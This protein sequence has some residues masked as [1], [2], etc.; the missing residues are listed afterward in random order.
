MYNYI[1]VV[2]FFCRGRS[3]TWT[4]EDLK[5]ALDDLRHNRGL[6]EVSRLYGISKPTLKRHTNNVNKVAKGDVMKRGRTTVLPDALEKELVEHISQLEGMLFGMTRNDI[7][8]LAFQIAET[9]NLPHNFNKKEGMAGKDWFTAFMKRHNL[10]LRQPQATSLARS[11]GFNK[12]SVNRFFDKLETLIKEHKLDA[13]R[14]FNCDETGLSTVQKKQ[15]KVV[16]QTGRHQ[17]GKITSAERGINTTAIFCANAAGN[18]IPPMLIYKRKRMKEELLDGAPPGTISFCND[19]G[20]MTNESFSSWMDLFVLHAKPSK[21]RPVLLILDGHATHSKNLAGITTARNSGVIMLSLPPHT[22]HK[23]QPLDVSFFKPLQ[24]YYVQECDKWLLNHPGR[25]LTVFQVAGILGSA[26]PRAASVGNI[27]NG[28]SKCGIW[29]CNRDVFSECDYEASSR[30]IINV[31]V[32]PSQG[33]ESTISP[34]S[35]HL[36]QARIASNLQEELVQPAMRPSTVTDQTQ[37]NSACRPTLQVPGQH[38]QSTTDVLSSQPDLPRVL[39]EALASP[40]SGTS[41]ISTLKPLSTISMS[42]SDYKTVPIESDGRCFFRSLAVSMTKELQ[43]ADRNID[44]VIDT[45]SLKLQEKITADSIRAEVVDFLCKNVNDYSDIDNATLCA[46]MPHSNYNSFLERVIDMSNPKTMVGE[47]EIIATVKVLKMPII[48]MNA[49]NGA[50]LKYGIDEFPAC[51]PIIV[52]FT[53]IGEHAGHYEYL[54][55]SQPPSSVYV[56]ITSISPLPIKEK[57]MSKKKRRT[58]Q[59][60]ILTSSPY[61]KKLA[62]ANN[63][64]TKKKI[65][66]H[67]VSDTSQAKIIGGKK[68]RSKPIKSAMSKTGMN[69]HKGQSWYCFICDENLQ[70]D[71][72]KCSVCHSWVHAACAGCENEKNYTCDL[73]SSISFNALCTFIFFYV[74]LVLFCLHL[75]TIYT[76]KWVISTTFISFKN[77]YF[78]N[79]H[80]IKHVENLQMSYHCCA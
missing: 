63:S 58:E 8:R 5:Q 14:I 13:L 77:C 18:H 55:P 28:F 12:A 2:F 9:N 7:R 15:Q 37:N 17:V 61:K 26:F 19:S 62:E 52:K 44:G 80:L 11:S 47:F 48:V 29:P 20:W 60:E 59:S 16:C 49:T 36:P 79:F 70:E 50:V 78:L 40:Q 66:I 54:I 64:K 24:T 57:N 67:T 42:I 32:L 21:E 75:G 38:Q 30:A 23:L 46:D 34:H 43:S 6:N 25:A 68:P 27:T 10:S 76:H 39:S 53:S 74:T 33:N 41:E 45:L 73:C 3:A 4:Q 71:M 51:S 69:M 31:P 1:F 35:S 56:P 65:E 22:T 72:I